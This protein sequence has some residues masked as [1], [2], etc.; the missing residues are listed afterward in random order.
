MKNRLWKFMTIKK[1]SDEF[2]CGFFH[3]I[4]SIIFVWSIC[5]KIGILLDIK[6]RFNKTEIVWE[7]FSCLNNESGKRYFF[8]IFNNWTFQAKQRYRMKSCFLEN[9]FFPFS[10]F[11][12][13]KEDDWD[14][15]RTLSN[16]ILFSV[17]ALSAEMY[18]CTY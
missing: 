9:F 6:N 10:D 5:Q 11:N 4:Q 8:K 18:L 1:Y 13:R 16:R 7:F 2:F 14:S 15:N 12:S 17:D 3:Y